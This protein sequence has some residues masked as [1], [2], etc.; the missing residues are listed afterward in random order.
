MFSLL[1]FLSR[2]ALVVLPVA[3]DLRVTQFSAYSTL[4][5]SDGRRLVSVS[6]QVINNGGE[7]V[8]PSVT[9][10][11]LGTSTIDLGTPGLPA[12][13]AAY[14][15]HFIRTA[16]ATVAVDILVDVNQQ[17]PERAEDNNRFT[18]AVEMTG[19]ENGRWQSIGPSAVINSNGQPLGVGRVTTLAIDPINPDTVYV[20]ARNS[21]LWKTRDGGATWF[22]L[23]DA[24]PSTRVDAVA[25]DPARPNRV[26]FASSAGVF[27]ST[28][29]GAVWVQLTNRDLHPRGHDGGALLIQNVPD[30]VLDPGL[31]APPPFQ[32]QPILY[33]SSEDGVQVSVDG[34]RSWSVALSG[35]VGSLQFS[36]TNQQRLFASV[37]SPSSDVGIFQT[38]DGGLTAA[39]WHKLQG[40]P[41]APLPTIP[42]SSRVW[43]AASGVHRWMSFLAGSAD[44]NRR[45]LWRSRRRVCDI[46]GHQ[47]FEWEQVPIHP[48]CDALPKDNSSF[49]FLHPTNASIVFKGGRFLCRDAFGGAPA[50]VDGLHVDQHAIGVAAANPSVVYVGNDGGLFRSDDAGATWRFVGEG[51]GVAEFLDGTVAPDGVRVAA[52]S[53]DNGAST[54]NGSASRW[55]ALG[56]GDVTSVAFDRADSSG[57]FTV[58][59]GIRQI[60]RVPGGGVSDPAVLP[61][62]TTGT[63]AGPMVTGQIVSTGTSPALVAACAGLWAGPSWHQT[64]PT[65]GSEFNRVRLGPAGMFLAGTSDGR[66]FAGQNVEALTP[67][68]TVPAGSITGLA[69]GGSNVFFASTS[70]PSGP[71]RIFRLECGATLICAAE[72]ISGGLRE[73]AVTTIAADPLATD[74]LIAAMGNGGLVRGIRTNGVFQWAAFNN[75]LPAGVIGTDLETTAKGHLILATWGRGMFRLHSGPLRTGSG[76]SVRGRLISLEIGLVDPDRPPGQTNPIL[77]EAV[78]DSRPDLF[79]SAINLT[80]TTRNVLQE[81]FANQRLVT[82]DFVPTTPNSGRITGARF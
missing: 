44:N 6:F 34:G 23:T 48:S 45:E 52:G 20:G 77:V 9:R 37:I 8:L 35:H 57:I 74:S 61:D 30:P 38:E 82:I 58:E 59:Q 42:G 39:S 65:A 32:P 13:Q 71:G 75:G 5:Q 50:R 17:V 10:V 29:G 76:D 31:I 18:Y 56:G 43:V 51:L 60:S 53:W 1:A 22:P 2:L 66:V 7:T 81:A 4:P 47:E 41:T 54:G 33:L 16:D 70:T 72:D 49:L 27:E 36:T 67:L 19:G 64:N 62:C 73:G 79:L 11:T 24:L 14:F 25:V 15:S 69:F 63:E 55:S 40:C 21:G 68:F 12:G 26:L 78:V 46:D 28:N 80:V 3:P